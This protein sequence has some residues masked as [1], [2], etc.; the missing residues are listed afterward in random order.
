MIKSNFP[1]LLVIFEQDVACKKF[2]NNLNKD[3]PLLN[4]ENQFHCEEFDSNVLKMQATGE[5][6]FYYNFYYTLA[7]VLNDDE[8]RIA[9]IKIEGTLGSA[10]I[11]FILMAGGIFKDKIDII[12]VHEQEKFNIE[13]DSMHKVLA[14]MR[15]LA[16]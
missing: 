7:D 10:E 8:Y 11:G 5:E 6:T 4:Q 16:T 3:V 12:S 13:F 9:R 15:A 1:Y 14:K 2:Y